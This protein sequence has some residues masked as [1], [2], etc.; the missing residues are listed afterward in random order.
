MS[1]DEKYLPEEL[2]GL[3]DRARRSDPAAWEV[4]YRGIYTRLLHY[5]QRRLRDRGEADD[6]VSETFARAYSAIDRFHWDGGGFEAWLYGILRN[7]VLETIRAS[8]RK[9][10]ALDLDR[11]SSD[12]GPLDQLLH[13]E[14]SVML[15]SAFARLSLEDQEILELRV[16]G[17]LDAAQ[18]A[19]VIGK[20][21]GAVRMAQLRALERLRST[22][23]ESSSEP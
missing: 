2:K 1:R 6:A 16:V 23:E 3:V 11:P 12:A 17:G 14:E 19:A 21:P 8:G 13:E 9:G 5:A 22:M 18:V 4:L 7:V 20:R 15:R 10:V